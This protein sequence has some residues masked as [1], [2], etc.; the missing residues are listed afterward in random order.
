MG[1]IRYVRSVAMPVW[2][3]RLTEAGFSS[4]WFEDT[5][6][7]SSASDICGDVLGLVDVQ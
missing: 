7:D 2:S 6:G 4:A 5:C 1:T 3:Q